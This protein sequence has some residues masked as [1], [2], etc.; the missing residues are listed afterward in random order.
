MSYL[1]LILNAL[2]DEYKLNSRQEDMGN[3]IS[4]ES[5]TYDMPIEDKQ[6]LLEYC[7]ENNVGKT[8]INHE[9]IDLVSDIDRI[10]NGYLHRVH[11]ELDLTK[12]KEELLKYI[13]MIKNDY[14]E[15]PNNISTVYNILGATLKDYKCELDKCDIYKFKNPK[16][17]NGRLADILFIYDCRRVGL[18]NEYIIDEID[19]YWQDIKNLYKD[20]FT[21]S[22]LSKYYKIA[23]KY[24]D[25]QTYKSFISGYDIRKK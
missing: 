18:K 25:N 22:T 17:I 4:L 21:P 23:I 2:G 7:I 6:K 10:D 1:C 13:E 16:P 5:L 19:R 24:I 9:S 20:N 11:I 15:D 3:S 14:D 12:P 8:F